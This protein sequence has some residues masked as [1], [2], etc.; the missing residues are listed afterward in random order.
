MIL[1][2]NLPISSVDIFNFLGR[3]S[4]LSATSYARISARGRNNGTKELKRQIPKRSVESCV[5][6]FVCTLSKLPNV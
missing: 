6:S 2:K 4:H 1:Q 3:K 5:G